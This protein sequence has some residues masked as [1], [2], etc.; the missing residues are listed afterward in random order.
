[1]GKFD[2]IL[3]C[4]DFDGT[5]FD[6]NKVPENTKK[7]IEYF[8]DECGKFCI[9]SGRGPEFLREMSHFIRGNTYSICHG[10]AIIC[11]IWTGDT[12]HDE[13]VGDEAFEVLEGLLSSDA[14]TLRIN[15]MRRDGVIDRY[16]PEEYFKNKESINHE[17][18]KITLNGMS[19][20]D[21]KLY[22][23]YAKEHPNPNYTLAR[24]FSSYIEIMKAEN[25]KG[26]SAKLLK[27]HLG[28]KLLVGMGD[29]ENDIPLFREVDV[30]Y[31]VGN[32]VDELKEIATKTVAETV[33]S[34]AAAAIIHD[35]EESLKK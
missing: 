16:T 20:D 24:S 10:G 3:I 31:A 29:Y 21:G 35:I 22:V 32:A 18:Y 34:G 27:K 9:C 14:E 7:A 17:A 33:S 11:D 19:E 30:S 26:F 12:L 2:G 25:T 5:I 15:I 28:A 4:S 6:G 23:K 8:M 1:M 13:Y